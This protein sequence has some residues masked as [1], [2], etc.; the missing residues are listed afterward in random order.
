MY[1]YSFFICALNFMFS[2]PDNL[3]PKLTALCERQGRHGLLVRWFRQEKTEVTQDLRS[4]PGLLV[5]RPKSRQT[6]WDKAWPVGDW[7]RL[8][9]ILPIIQCASIRKG[10]QVK[11]TIAN[12]Y[13]EC[14]NLWRIF[15]VKQGGAYSNHWAFE[16]WCWWNTDRIMFADFLQSQS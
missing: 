12:N 10:S 7:L 3:L 9:H 6:A 8:V 14:V 16:G 15:S 11:E 1:N 4:R 13:T 5:Y 2:R